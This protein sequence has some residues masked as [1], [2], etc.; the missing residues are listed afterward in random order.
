[1]DNAIQQ[2]QA[3]HWQIEQFLYKESRLI[4]DR[5]LDDWLDLWTMDCR[6]HV[7]VRHN[8]FPPVGEGL[9]PIE[10]EIADDDGAAWIDDTKMLLFARVMRLRT[11]KAWS[12][13]PLSRTRRLVSNVEV[14]NPDT[15][16]EYQVF[17]NM[18]QFR[19]RRQTEENLFACQRRD[20]LVRAGDSFQIKQRTVILD[21]AVL[22]ASFATFI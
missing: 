12:E 21:S 8:A 16:D 11:G 20:V 22:N 5:Q 13:S 14:Q 6:Y 2:Q 17:S 7:P 15:D 1:M 10:Q 9:V 3:L 18:L 19:S 4:D